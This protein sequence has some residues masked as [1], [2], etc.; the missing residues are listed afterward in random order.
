MNNRVIL[1]YNIAE[2]CNLPD[3]CM[4][5]LLR[6]W[7]ALS[8]WSQRPSH[9]KRPS[10]FPPTF[11]HHRGLGFLAIGWFQ[12]SNIIFT[13]ISIEVESYVNFEWMNMSG[14]EIHRFLG[15]RQDTTGRSCSLVSKTI[16]NPSWSVHAKFVEWI[17]SFLSN[18]YTF[19]LIDIFGENIE[20]KKGSQI[21]EA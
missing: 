14:R 20:S 5:Q 19:V 13:T 10:L 12:T 3:I 11:Q 18:I 6:L 4:T 16:I 15:I 2:S 1:G 7:Q 9:L 17:W 8:W 21:L